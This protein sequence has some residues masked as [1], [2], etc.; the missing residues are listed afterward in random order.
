MTKRFLA[1]ML[2][3]LLAS[4]A[5][6]HAWIA[7]KGGAVAS[8]SQLLLSS[9]AGNLG[10]GTADNFLPVGYGALSAAADSNYSVFT[11]SGTITAIRA[12][13]VGAP[14][15][16]QTWTVTLRKNGSDTGIA[17]TINSGSSSKCNGSG[18]VAFAAGDYASLRIAGANTPSITRISIALIFAPTT[19][20]DTVL[21]TQGVALS[22]SATQGAT[23]SNNVGPGA[24][25]SRRY[26]VL[27]DGGT[28]DKFYVNA[29]A[30]GAGTSYAY[31]V[32]KNGSTTTATCS[33]AD[34]ATTCNDTSHSFSVAAGDDAQIQAVPTNTPAAATAALGVRYV[35]TTAASFPLIGSFNT[36]DSAASTFYYAVSGG[37]GIG[38]ATEANNQN[39]AISMTIT[40][41]SVNLITAP[42][43]G[44]SRVFTLR[45]NETDT[46]LTCTIADTN[47]TCTATGS[48]AVADDDRLDTSDAPTG[49]PAT[50]ALGISYLATR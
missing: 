29:N 45:K 22:N 9:S 18:S 36:V 46:A 14:T 39:V 38:T 37:A 27:P 10:S 49:S 24:I 30:P 50:G 35:P 34:A 40:K 7:Q 15:G 17:C 3:A 31:T 2:A 4:P 5:P 41:L 25:S 6:A 1:G 26:D 33:I 20:N 16:A 12:K 47:K 8:T 28:I 19:A 32:D 13:T 43:A 21:F 11:A 42:G 44:K 23:I 48:I